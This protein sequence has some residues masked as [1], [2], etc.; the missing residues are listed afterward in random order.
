MFLGLFLICLDVLAIEVLYDVDVKWYAPSI[1]VACPLRVL[2]TSVDAWAA[3][4]WVYH[5]PGSFIR[6]D[7]IVL[8]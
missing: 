7:I 6:C 1:A 5:L 3:S 4:R 8:V 2:Q